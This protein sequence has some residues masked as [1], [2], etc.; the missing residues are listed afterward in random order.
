MSRTIQARAILITRVVH[1]RTD[2]SDRID[3]ISGKRPQSNGKLK[4]SRVSIV[5]VVFSLFLYHQT[6]G[7][8]ITKTENSI[9]TSKHRIKFKF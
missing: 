1:L 4:M 2:W 8:R 5:G 6:N 9:K 3:R 7:I